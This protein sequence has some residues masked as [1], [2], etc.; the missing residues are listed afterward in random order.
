MKFH[1]LAT[2]LEYNQNAS[3]IF[4]VG[5]LAL[6]FT[7]SGEHAAARAIVLLMEEYLN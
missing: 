1:T 3:N 7:A 6:I 5:S 2:T 4:G